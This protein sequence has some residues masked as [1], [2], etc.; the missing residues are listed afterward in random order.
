MYFLDPVFHPNIDPDNGLV[1]ADILKENWNPYFNLNSVMI[2][3]LDLLKEPNWKSPFNVDA[4][5]IKSIIIKGRKN[6]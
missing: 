2:S 1:C 6:Q 4:G 5:N 3:I